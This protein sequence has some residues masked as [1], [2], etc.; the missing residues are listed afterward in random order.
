MH[1]LEHNECP[2]H[3]LFID[4]WY[5]CFHCLPTIKQPLFPLVG[6]SLSPLQPISPSINFLDR[7]KAAVVYQFSWTRHQTSF[8]QSQMIVTSLFMNG[9]SDAVQENII[10]QVVEC[11]EGNL[12]FS[13][14]LSLYSSSAK[15]NDYVRITFPE[16]SSRR[17]LRTAPL[18]MVTPNK[19]SR[20]L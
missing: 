15:Q 6:S 5:R 10:V 4:Q 3:D 19:E 13:R 8:P 11:S 9:E 16:N 18:F 12:S 1:L 7:S 20:I 14:I 17:C 2:S